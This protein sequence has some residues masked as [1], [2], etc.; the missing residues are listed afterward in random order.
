MNSEQ[1]AYLKDEIFSLTL[2]GTVLRGKVYRKNSTEV[3]RST[4]RG[5][6]R[7]ELERLAQK[8][9]GGVQEREH[10][11]NIDKLANTLSRTHSK[12]LSGGRFRIGSAQKALNLYLKYLWWLD[13]IPSPPH[14]P[15]DAMVLSR[16]SGCSEVRWTQLDSLAEY[17]RI[18]ECA[19]AAAKGV[20]LSEWE[21]YLYNASQPLGR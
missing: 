5:A 10:F 17:K 16:V 15:F 21:L 18:V 8:Y 7:V 1:L 11:G 19:K 14:C 20:S 9:E 13:R 3:E 6:L 12:A 2:M 4:L